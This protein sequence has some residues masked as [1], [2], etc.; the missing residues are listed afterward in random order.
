ME[1][2]L[3]GLEVAVG[4]RGIALAPQALAFD[5]YS[6]NGADAI[7]CIEAIQLR[8]DV[9]HDGIRHGLRPVAVFLV[10]LKPLKF[11]LY[12][13]NSVGRLC[14]RRHG[15]FNGLRILIH[16]VCDFP[17]FVGSVDVFL[18]PSVWVATVWFY[19]VYFSPCVVNLICNAIAQFCKL[20]HFLA[21]SNKVCVALLVDIGIPCCTACGGVH[22]V[23]GHKGTF[24]G[25][26]GQA[27]NQLL[28]VGGAVRADSLAGNK[29]AGVVGVG[30]HANLEG[31]MV[32]GA[33]GL[34][35][36]LHYHILNVKDV[37]VDLR[38]YQHEA[39][40]IVDAG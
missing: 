40:G 27:A 23:D 4:Q 20:F 26:V 10:R 8:L 28:P 19:L 2:L 6:A 11:A 5:V 37:G 9:T 34:G 39:V 16:V 32:G 7:R 33:G 24:A 14:Q 36:E 30:H 17:V 22:V 25:I 18:E 15:L 38:G 1:I 21:A 29:G 35:P 31:G 12:R 3:R 13:V